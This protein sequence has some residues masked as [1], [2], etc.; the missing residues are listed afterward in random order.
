M[1]HFPPFFGGIMNYSDGRSASDTILKLRETV[2]KLRKENEELKTTIRVLAK[3]EKKK[4]NKD[5]KK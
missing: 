2:A 1:V 3:M 4:K 5:D